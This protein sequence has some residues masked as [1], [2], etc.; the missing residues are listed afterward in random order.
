MSLIPTR[1]QEE[2][3]KL[4]PPL[5]PI[6][7]AGD[8]VIY[9]GSDEQIAEIRAAKNG[10]CLI[11]EH[12]K[13]SFVYKLNDISSIDGDPVLSNTVTHYLICNPHPLA[14]MIIR[15]SQTGQPVWI[16]ELIRNYDFPEG[17]SN[18]Y[19]VSVTTTPDW[20][21]PNAE[22]SFTPFKD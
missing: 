20:N 21:I 13:E 8:W 4:L 14:E 2:M 12:S 17:L 5:K 3:N 16:R 7:K 6:S 18:N 9:T 10:I 1:E 19:V 15:Q 11:F 22:Y